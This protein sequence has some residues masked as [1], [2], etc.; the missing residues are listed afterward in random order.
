MSEASA[1]LILSIA[2]GYDIC[3]IDGSFCVYDRGEQPG[4]RIPEDAIVECTERGWVEIV[5]AEAERLQLT[6]NGKYWGRKLA[7]ERQRKLLRGL[8]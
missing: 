5:G 3:I 6:E 4:L 8:R 7:K 2:F 1:N